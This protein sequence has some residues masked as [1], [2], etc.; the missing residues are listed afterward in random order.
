MTEIMLILFV[1]LYVYNYIFISYNHKMAVFLVHPINIVSFYFLIFFILPYILGEYYVA[2]GFSYLQS[3]LDTHGDFLLLIVTLVYFVI[4]IA[5]ALIKK[6]NN[7]S[8]IQREKYGKI[9]ELFIFLYLGFVLSILLLLILNA[10]GS[11]FNNIAEFTIK[12]RN[13]N[14]FFLMIIY[15]VELLPI[16][17]ILLSKRISKLFLLFI[18]LTS[19]G[20]IILV[21]A[22]TLI[23]SMILSLVILGLSYRKLNIKKLF[24]I[25]MIFSVFFISGS[26]V[27]NS[28]EDA[29]Y[30]SLKE[31][32]ENLKTYF[33]NNSDQLFTSLY[34]IDS[35]EKGEIEYQYGRTIIDAVYFF[36]P[37]AIW[38]EKPRSYYPSRLVFPDIIEQGIDSNTKQTI[39]FG[40]IA[41]PYLD[42]G[43]IGI[44]VLNVLTIFFLIKIF[45]K[46][47]FNRNLLSSKKIVLYV[48]I[49]SHIHQIYI[50]GIWSH[51]VSIIL[52][53]LIYIYIIFFLFQNF[54]KVF[55]LRQH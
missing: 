46:I 52:F 30:L 51:I 10:E 23:L 50:L 37:T 32:A 8:P 1:A 55:K 43:I 6:K 36:I 19:M 54:S 11:I 20:I 18:I 31:K 42:F 5:N 38:P 9:L 39:N 27:R 44:L 47:I 16:I 53:N 12:L 21:G 22:R 40:M 25:G 49:Y 14:A 7:Q 29:S 26:L 41:R 33:S 28:G 17:Y 2:P 34:I 45:Y 4:T 48:Y 35:I 3:S 13:G 24:L 15:T